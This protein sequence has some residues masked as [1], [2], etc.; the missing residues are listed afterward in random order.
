MAPARYRPRTAPENEGFP[1]EWTLSDVPG[2]KRTP[3]QQEDARPGGRAPVPPAKSGDGRLVGRASSLLPD[4][5]NYGP[6]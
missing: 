5:L 2:G 3:G 6:A 1:T 4:F